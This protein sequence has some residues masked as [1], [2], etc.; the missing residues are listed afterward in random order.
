MQVE[1]AS[2]PTS[3]LQDAPV[4]EASARVRERVIA[5]R[6]RQVSRQGKINAQLQGVALEKICAL[7]DSERALLRQSVERL[8]LS[9]RSYHRV[10]KVARTL[11]DL[12]G[13]QNIGAGQIA[14]ALAY[15]NLDRRLPEKA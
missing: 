15:R 2:L 1:V 10:L 13:E 12:A 7:G 9:A 11:A 5:A 14:E 3:Q 6:Q 8:G 4:G